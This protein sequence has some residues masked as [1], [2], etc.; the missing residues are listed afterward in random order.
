MKGTVRSADKGEYLAGTLSA[1][2]GEELGD[3]FSWVVVQDM[4]VDGA[5]EEAI[6][7]VDGV[8]HISSPFHFNAVSPNEMIDPA[9]RGTLNV[10]NAAN[11]A[12]RVKRVVLT[13]SV[14]AVVNPEPHSPREFTEEVR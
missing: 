2:L 5:F 4:A 9:V 3:R 10:L 7:D 14:A 11:D 8:C 1:Q 12:G 13:S 6:R